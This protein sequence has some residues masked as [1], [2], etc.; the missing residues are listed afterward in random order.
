[1]TILKALYYGYANFLFIFLKNNR[2]YINQYILG[3]NAQGV[4]ESLL[5]RQFDMKIFRDQ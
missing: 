1:M 4:W 5:L 3:R 2:D